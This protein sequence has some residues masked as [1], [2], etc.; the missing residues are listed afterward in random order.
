MNANDRPLPIDDR[1]RVAAADLRERAAARPVPTFDPA[2][3]VESASTAAAPQPRPLRA[4][5]TAP[6]LLAV[7]AAVLLVAG[8]AW[9]VGGVGEDPSADPAGVTSTSQPPLLPSQL[10]EGSWEL[11]GAADTTG[12]E[13][14]DTPT[15][16]LV[17]YGAEPSR[18]RVGVVQVKEGFEPSD[19]PAEPDATLTVDGTEVTVFDG[20]LFGGRTAVVE[21]DDGTAVFVMGDDIERQ[22]IAELAAAVEPGDPPT[23]AEDA[24]PDG[25]RRLGEEP[26]GINQG[27]PYAMMRG[28]NTSPARLAVYL[29]DDPDQMLSISVGPA[30]DPN[31]QLRSAAIIP[32]ASEHEEVDIAG[33][34]GLVASVPVQDVE[35]GPIQMVTWVTEAEAVVRV[36]GM[37]VEREDL[38]AVARSLDPVTDAEWAQ[39]IED[40][41]LGRLPGANLG[42]KGPTS[43]PEADLAA[44]EFDDGTAWVLRVRTDGA[45]ELDVALSSPDGSSGSA[46]TTSSLSTDTIISTTVTDVGGRRFLAALAR[47]SIE[48]VEVRLPD[49]TVVTATPTAA[50]PP[51][52]LVHPDTAGPGGLVWFVAE[53]PLTDSDLHLF[54]GTGAEAVEVYPMVDGGIDAEASATTVPE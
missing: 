9:A 1:G 11:A 30:A 22:A 12:V 34:Q 37:G 5:R 15:S 48:R 8:A 38:L 44:G 45:L 27:M 21:F 33:R 18:P 29:T 35:M 25:W 51:G 14:G 2:E 19:F 6:R 3:L 36:T 47:S 7:A 13:L 16:A 10:P 23:V 20:T 53:L 32:M 17:L 40:S 43:P 41:Q 46:M 50:V 52:D 54:D 39:V 4:G 42:E 49:G 24:L 31:A 26:D 28:A